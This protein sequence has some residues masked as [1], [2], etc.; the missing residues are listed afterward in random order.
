MHVH[1]AD[2]SC[3]RQSRQFASLHQPKAKTIHDE[4][5]EL[6]GEGAHDELKPEAKT[7]DD[8]LAELFGE[9]A[10]DELKPKAKMSDD[11]IDELYD[12]H[13]RADAVARKRTIDAI[14]ASQTVDDMFLAIASGPPQKR[15]ASGR[16]CV[17]RAEAATVASH[18]MPVDIWSEEEELLN[19]YP[20]IDD[21]SDDD[22]VYSV[23]QLELLERFGHT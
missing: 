13:C 10:H 22:E 1:V 4:L 23:K 20:W 21:K 3:T 12:C 7:I 8:E 14:M 15:I 2:R 5:D 19:L 11:E 6:F 17:K 9:G 18:K 16:A